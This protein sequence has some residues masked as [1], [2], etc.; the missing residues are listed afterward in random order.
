MLEELS[1][2]AK[3]AGLNLHPDKTKILA[4]KVNRRGKDAR[5]D[6]LVD[7][8][9]VEVLSIDQSTEYLGRRLGF[10][11][12]HDSEID[13]R[14]AKA[15][16][17]FH[18]FKSELCCKAIPIKDR[19]R[20]L[21]AVITPS[22]LYGSSCWTMTCD[23]ERKLRSTQRR[24]LR[25]ICQTW[26]MKECNGDAEAWVEWIRRATHKAEE[27]MSIVGMESWI[28]S[29]KRKK[30]RWAGHVARMTDDRWTVKSLLWMP[31]HANRRVGR[32]S[33]RWS[34]DI[35]QFCQEHFDC[36]A[37]EWVL[38]AQSRE[39]WKHLEDVFVSR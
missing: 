4:N 38:Y 6:V 29:Q 22:V 35:D 12:F 28:T 24:M 21:D 9:T 17:K 30:W 19:L 23:R 14:I 32:P 2:E 3:S 7:G 18:K 39:D 26:R 16:A 20:L 27:L 1:I 34:D 15:W 33:R 31:E 8:M 10:Q 37:G 5:R 13:H 11:D 25:L 36:E